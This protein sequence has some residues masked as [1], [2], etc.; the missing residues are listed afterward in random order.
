M[1]A[2]NTEMLP[3]DVQRLL[4]AGPIER[5]TSLR[6]RAEVERVMREFKIMKVGLA[7]LDYDI[8]MLRLRHDELHRR[9]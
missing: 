1:A 2:I 7:L 8:R 4:L 6:S 9:G 3:R 5:A